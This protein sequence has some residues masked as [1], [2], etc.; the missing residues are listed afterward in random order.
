MTAVFN[1]S[2]AKFLKIERL[3]LA[4][5]REPATAHYWLGR[6]LGTPEREAGTRRIPRQQLPHPRVSLQHVDIFY[7]LY[8]PFHRRVYMILIY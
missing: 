3:A 6:S 5:Q 1:G 8:N 4:S 7:L 2:L